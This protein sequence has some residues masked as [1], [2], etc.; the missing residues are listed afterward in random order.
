MR[1]PSLYLAGPISGCTFDGC[2][3]WRNEFRKLMPPEVE[4]LSPMR[5]KEYLSAEQIIEHDYPD[6][7]MSC[8]R[9]IMTR[10]YFDCTHATAIIA[11]LRG[12]E[13]VSIG[14]VMEI[15][16]AFAHRVPVIAI[17]EPQGNLHD[18]PMIREA[19]GFRVADEQQAARVALSLLNLPNGSE[20]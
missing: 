3:T 7:V 1:S 10:D 6:T 11:D 13:R 16:W 19:I 9:G 2:T 18:H 14:T 15:A 5:D 12:A 4:C 20:Q 17:L 8:Q